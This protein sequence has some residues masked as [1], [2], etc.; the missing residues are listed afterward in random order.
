MQNNN[1]E[2]QYRRMEHTEDE[3]QNQILGR[4]WDYQ[5][6]L[7]ECKINDTNRVADQAHVV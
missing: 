6:Q 4:T 3:E 2:E 1:G 5:I 7:S